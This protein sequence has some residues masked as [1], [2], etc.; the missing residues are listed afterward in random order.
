MSKN[1][2]QR[3]ERERKEF[4]LEAA[5]AKVTNN[6]KE[7][8]ND[9]LGLIS[10]ACGLAAWGWSV[11][12]PNS[13]IVFGSILLLAAVVLTVLA[14]RRMWLLGNLASSGVALVALAA[15]CFFDWYIVVKPQRGKPFQDLLVHGYHLTSECGSLA[16]RQRMPDWLRD[17]SKGWQAQVDQL[18]TEKL[19]AK[20]S[21]IWLGAI[22]YGKVSDV[23]TVAYQCTWLA[24]KV[25]AL[26]TIVSTEYDSSL[27]HK[28]YNGPTYWFEPVNGKVDISEALKA[29]TPQSNIAIEDL[30]NDKD[31]TQPTQITG[32][33]PHKH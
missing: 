3:R 2:R 16:A 21:Q 25:G 31:S 10:F 1:R 6:K 9:V 27:K 26:E 4:K 11:I 15:F 7:R 23:N 14:L 32:T 20:D 24:N 22:I 17:E 29:G 19:P 28:D 8:F 30:G 12:A 33:V 13:S 5:V 18:I